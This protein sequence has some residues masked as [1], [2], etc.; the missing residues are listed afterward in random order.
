MFNLNNLFHK[1][2]FSWDYNVVQI[3][4]YSNMFK[5]TRW[6]YVITDRLNKEFI[7]FEIRLG[8]AQKLIYIPFYNVWY[9]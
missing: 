3:S 2:I 7:L 9:K 5:L 4:W 6:I 8:N 1:R